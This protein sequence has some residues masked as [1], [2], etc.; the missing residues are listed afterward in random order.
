MADVKRRQVS[1]DEAI[2]HVGGDFA[3]AQKLQ[4]AVCALAW[5]IT[6]FHTLLVIFYW[7]RHRP[8]AS[9]THRMHKNGRRSMRG[10]SRPP[11]SCHV[12]SPA[13][14]LGLQITGLLSCI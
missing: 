3:L 13:G 10:C 11:L 9:K 6:A 5:S 4:T 1:I 7:S 12:C 2:S 14:R 8:T